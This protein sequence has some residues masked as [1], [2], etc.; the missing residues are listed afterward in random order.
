MSESENKESHKK[1]HKCPTEGENYDNPQ[2]IF[3]SK[4]TSDIIKK[5]IQLDKNSII[6][7]FG[8]GTGLIGLNFISEVK[9]V[10]FEDI[11]TVMLDY[12]QYKLDTQGIKNYTIYKGIM[13][14]YKNEENVDLITAGM[15]VHHVED[16]QSLFK[17]FVEILK[18]GGYLCLTDL[19]KDAPM[20]KIGG[21]SHHH[22]MPHNG[23]EPEK[24]CEELKKTGFISTEVK[25]VSSIVFKGGDGKDII[26]ERFMIIAKRE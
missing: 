20:F 12:L 13:E 19:K 2:T 18:P 15:V 6:F 8:A 11:S 5:S 3:L 17:K 24:L 1:I 25:N 14:D 9:H 4:E 22:K 10:I 16:L 26:S 23:F 7:D 21:H